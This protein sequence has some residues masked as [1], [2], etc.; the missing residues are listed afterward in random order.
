MRDWV[1][2]TYNSNMPFDQVAVRAIP[3]SVMSYC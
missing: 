2:N 3:E 1:I